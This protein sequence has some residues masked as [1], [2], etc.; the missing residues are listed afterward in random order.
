MTGEIRQRLCFAQG[1]WQLILL[2]AALEAED[3]RAGGVRPATRLVLYAPYF[4]RDLREWMQRLAPALREW[5]GIVSVG[6]PLRNELRSREWPLPVDEWT[7]LVR[8]QCGVS[9]SDELW[10]PH[11]MQFAERVASIAYSRASIVTYEEGLSTYLPQIVSAWSTRDVRDLLV[12]LPGLLR[13]RRLR[14]HLISLQLSNWRTPKSFVRRVRCVY[15]FLS[16]RLSFAEPYSETPVGQIPVGK[17]R[18][19]IG[20]AVRGLSSGFDSSAQVLPENHVLVLSAT[21]YPDLKVTWEREAEIYRELVAELIEKGYTVHWKEHPRETKPFWTAFARDFSASRFHVPDVPHEWPV[22][23][24]YL[25][26]QYPI[27]LGACS[28]ALYS[29]PMLYGTRTY[30]FGKRMAAEGG[31]ATLPVLAMTIRDIEDYGAL[32]SVGAVG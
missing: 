7:R 31:G 29:L 10:L 27:C 12:A 20:K 28:S 4:N 21:L 15:G 18:G 2:A 22:E 3:E 8:E 11:V 5:D 25:R 24:L 17:V 1:P 9:D 6:H 30:S 14:A 32:P 19:L 16:P 26:Q 23:M 13:R